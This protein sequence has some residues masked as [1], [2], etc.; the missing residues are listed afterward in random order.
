MA[1]LLYII[2]FF[3]AFLNL[4]SL[5]SSPPHIFTLLHVFFPSPS[6]PLH[7][8][9][10]MLSCVSVGGHWASPGGSVGG[11][12]EGRVHVRRPLGM[13]GYGPWSIV[14]MDTY[15]LVSISGS[16]QMMP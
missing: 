7:I 4:V 14:S 10:L 16:V 11:G 2:Y 1:P 6:F 15:L 3:L 5:T 8:L 12:R 13:S 9:T